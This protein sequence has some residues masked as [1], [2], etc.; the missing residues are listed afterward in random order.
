MNPYIH[1]HPPSNTGRLHR[2]ASTPRERSKHWKNY[3]RDLGL[4]I[5]APQLPFGKEN[6]HS[7]SYNGVFEDYYYWTPHIVKQTLVRVFEQCECL[8][9]EC[10]LITLAGLEADVED[11]RSFCL[12]IDGYISGFLENMSYD[13]AYE[14]SLELEEGGATPINYEPVI[15]WESDLGHAVG[16]AMYYICC[17]LYHIVGPD[18][19]A[20]NLVDGAFDIECF[21]VTRLD[22]EG[23]HELLGNIVRFY[24]AVEEPTREIEEPH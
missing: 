20:R 1:P 13:D 21:K 23:Q 6:Y 7:L 15:D 22:T 5:N 18:L 8:L 17:D 10:L 12:T 19:R 11:Y 14:E 16:Q 9:T 4:S 24:V 3:N 2:Q